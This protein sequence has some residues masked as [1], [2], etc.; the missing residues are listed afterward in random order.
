MIMG[1]VWKGR[2]GGVSG[3]PGMSCGGQV[4]DVNS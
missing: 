3:S 2:G 4:I 1:E